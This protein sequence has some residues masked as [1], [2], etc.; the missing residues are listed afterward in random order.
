MSQNI[1]FSRTAYFI[2]NVRISYTHITAKAESFRPSH[3]KNSMKIGFFFYVGTSETLYFSESTP[4]IIILMSFINYLAFLP[5][6]KCSK[7]SDILLLFISFFQLLLLLL[8]IAAF[9]EFTC[10][11]P[12][13][14]N[15][16]PP[17]NLFASLIALL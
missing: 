7:K 17:K 4:D 3:L 12:D 14:I 5:N 9:V 11:P 16:L 8:P 2:R 1:R 15:E 13:A 10:A 6:N